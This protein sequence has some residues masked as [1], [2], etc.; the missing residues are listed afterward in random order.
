MDKVI[1]YPIFDYF[2]DIVS[3]RPY[4]V[5]SAT[6]PASERV[7]FFKETQEIDTFWASEV[8][9]TAGTLGDMATINVM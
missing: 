5:I 8:T 7:S 6:S 2:S 3:T 9:L 4:K 1:R